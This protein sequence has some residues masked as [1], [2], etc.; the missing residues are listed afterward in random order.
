MPAPKMPSLGNGC[1]AR[2]WLLQSK[3][4]NS[5]NANTNASF[6]T[7]IMALSSGGKMTT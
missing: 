5:V 2:A 3:L 6:E 1:A 4:A 7:L